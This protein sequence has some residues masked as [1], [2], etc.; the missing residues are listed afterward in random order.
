MIEIGRYNELTILRHT[1][2]GLY[3]GDEEGE[4]VLLPNKYCPETFEIDDKIKV[5]VYRDSED[6]KIA[7]N[8]TPKIFFNEFSLLEV[9]AITSVG[10]FKDW[11]MEKE[12]M[13]PYREQ[14][15]RMEEG[16]WYIVYLDI[17]DKTDRLFASN[18]IDRYLQNEDLTVEIGEEVDLIVMQQSDLGFTVIINN[19]HKGLVFENEIFVDLNV[20]D[21]LKGF[22]KNIREDNKIDISLQAIGYEKFNDVNTELIYKKLVH[23]DGFLS[24]SDKSSPDEIYSEFGISKKAFKKSLGSLYKERKITIKPDGIRIIKPE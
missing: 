2:V 16:R 19:L 24:I 3:L 12:L 5:Y 9:T 15:Q 23:N 10:A 14:R 22:V 21:R 18:R 1:T 8:L 6:R 20:G 4:D 13:V 17:D 7:T 11:G